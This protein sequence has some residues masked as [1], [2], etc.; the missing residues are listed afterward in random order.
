MDILNKMRTLGA[1]GKYDLCCEGGSNRVQADNK[2][3]AAAKESIYLTKTEQ[4]VCKLFK[5]LMTNKCNHDC[6]YCPNG[7]RCE[8]SQK[9]IT[10]SWM[11]GAP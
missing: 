9:K 8:K 5:T 1:A 10:S 7:T 2:L 11:T 4:G 3:L 6:A